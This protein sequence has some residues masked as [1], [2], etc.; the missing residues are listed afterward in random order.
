[1]ASNLQANPVHTAYK[2]LHQKYRHVLPFKYQVSSPPQELAPFFA[3]L[4]PFDYMVWAW[5]LAS[6]ILEI[7]VLLVMDFTWNRLTNAEG[8]SYL[9]EGTKFGLFPK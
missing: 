8:S 6:I 3:L 4:L 1:M 9:Y 5:V 2:Q 7:L